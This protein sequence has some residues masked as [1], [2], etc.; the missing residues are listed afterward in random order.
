[1]E[2]RGQNGRRMDRWRQG[3]RWRIKIRVGEEAGRVTWVHGM[4][5]VARVSRAQTKTGRAPARVALAGTKAWPGG[6]GQRWRRPPRARA[7][8]KSQQLPQRPSAG[9]SR[10]PGAPG[11]AAGPRG[12]PAG[13]ALGGV[14]CKPGAGRHRL[15]S[16]SAA[17]LG[18]GK[19]HRVS[20]PE[21]GSGRI[22]EGRTKGGGGWEETPNTKSRVWGAAPGYL[23]ALLAECM[24]PALDLG[25]LGG[26]HGG[27]GSRGAQA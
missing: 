19:G 5:R 9:P 6:R 12:P 11:G 20:D 13:L 16:S 22:G 23:Y 10:S 27:R 8:Y 7:N 14:S 1:M 2:R 18:R 15:A 3:Y 21:S 24:V 4:I 25:G 26:G 17:R